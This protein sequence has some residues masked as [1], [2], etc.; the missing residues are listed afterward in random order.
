MS[1]VSFK[2]EVMIKTKILVGIALVIS[3][4]DAFARKECM[5]PIESIFTGYTSTTS[6]I[7][8]EHGDG[9]SPS[10]VRLPFVANDE[11]IV[12]RMLSVLLSA[13]MGG[14]SVTFRY[15]QG[16]DGSPASCTPTV[17]QITEA[18]WIK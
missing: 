10:V 17:K 13:H 15:L 7:H 14:K 9:Y 8:V 3:C 4:Q 18:V 5:R 1:F 16:E 2:D 12:D 11:K 6:K